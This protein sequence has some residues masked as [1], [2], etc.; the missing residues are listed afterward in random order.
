M[1]KVQLVS[2]VSVLSLTAVWATQSS[3]EPVI[4][5]RSGPTDGP[6]SCPASD[7]HVIEAVT[8]GIFETIGDS[9]MRECGGLGWR[10]VADL[11]MRDTSQQCPSPWRETSNRGRS[12][13]RSFNTG[14]CE[15]V[16]F[17]VMGGTYTH[18][19]GRVTGFAESSVDAFLRNQLDGVNV[20]Y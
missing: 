10:Q 3:V 5:P 13:R 11:D 9:I 8:T 18:V 1:A 15:G 14:G 17:P 6:R 12:C 2:L 20:T 19:C 16:S 7:V 4:I